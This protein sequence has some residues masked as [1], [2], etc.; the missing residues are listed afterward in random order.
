MSYKDEI[1]AVLAQMDTQESQDNQQ[2]QQEPIEDVYIFVVRKHEVE[3]EDQSNIVDS[4]PAPVS[5]QKDSFLSAYL[6]VCFPY[7]SFFQHSHC[8]SIA[9]TTLQ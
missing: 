8:N 7:F 9:Y 1:K 3:E 2:S 5:K 6:F 4:T